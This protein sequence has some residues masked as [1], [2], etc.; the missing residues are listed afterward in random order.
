MIKLNNHIKYKGIIHNN[1]QLAQNASF[2]RD[3]LLPFLLYHSHFVT[4]LY[5]SVNSYF[6]SYFIIL[7]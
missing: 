4:F 6:N 2:L 1:F 5:S 7:V 3:C